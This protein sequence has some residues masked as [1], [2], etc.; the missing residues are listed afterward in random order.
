M[1]RDGYSREDA[2]ARV[3][4][5]M[6]ISEK[7]SY[8]DIVIDNS[9]MR[10]ELEARVQSLIHELDAAAGWTWRISWL[11]PPV[12]LLSA[13]WI[14]LRRKYAKKRRQRAG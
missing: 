12:G 6:S 8:A 5:Q 9:G 11:L 1:Q 3:K 7:V 13:A 2:F 4:S 10:N 14:L